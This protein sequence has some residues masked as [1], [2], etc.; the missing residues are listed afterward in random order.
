MYSDDSDDSD[1]ELVVGAPR[2]PVPPADSDDSD[3]E[4]VVG[5]KRPAPESESDGDEPLLLALRRTGRAQVCPRAGDT[6][7]TRRAAEQVRLEAKGG[8]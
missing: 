2:A 4:V 5:T 7:E 6:P 1:D 8:D 3:D